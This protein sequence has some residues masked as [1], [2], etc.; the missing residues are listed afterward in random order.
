[1]YERIKNKGI[2]ENC[3]NYGNTS[4]CES[5]HNYD[6][7][8]EESHVR[9]SNPSDPEQVKKLDE[10][11]KL[12][13]D[14]VIDPVTARKA[15]VNCVGLPFP[16]RSMSP[17]MPPHVPTMA[18]SYSYP[19]DGSNM[20]HKNILT[21]EEIEQIQS[22]KPSSN[23]YRR[24]RIYALMQKATDLDALRCMCTHHTDQGLFAITF[25]QTPDVSCTVCGD[26]WNGQ[27][28]EPE[29][30]K[31]SVEYLIAVVNEIKLCIYAADDNPERSIYED[32]FTHLIPALKGLPELYSLVREALDEEIASA[33]PQLPPFNP[34]VPADYSMIPPKPVAKNPSVSPIRD[35]NPKEEK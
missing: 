25:A 21:S 4:L 18:M 28:I 12:P 15:H 32:Y 24:Q 11:I 20:S 8:Q 22:S 9:L 6:R 13:P 3:V 10:P 30:L 2:C 5:C 1:M 14:V 26:K 31:A 29:K 17:V 23:S 33:K 35:N 7:Y 27:M 34:M 19:D 16:Y